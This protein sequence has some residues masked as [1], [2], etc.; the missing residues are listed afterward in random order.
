MIF[1]LAIFEI[2]FLFSHCNEMCKL[3][4][5]EPKLVLSIILFYFS[6]ASY[7]TDLMFKL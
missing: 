5:H 1:K 6:L 2:L 4:N 7:I 3:T